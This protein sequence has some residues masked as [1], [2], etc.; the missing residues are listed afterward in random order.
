M[1]SI[2]NFINEKLTL[3][4]QSKPYHNDKLNSGDMIKDICWG[5][6]KYFEQLLQT[7]K[8]KDDVEDWLAKNEEEHGSSRMKPCLT[9]EIAEEMYNEILNNDWVDKDAL[10]KWWDRD[11]ERWEWCTIFDVIA[12][13]LRNLEIN[14]SLK[15]FDFDKCYNDK[16]DHITIGA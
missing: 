9:N 5:I 1:I 3:N 13:I 10:D 14:K 12:E 8:S 16:S 4:K 2:T 11:M 15:Y 7:L 6:Y